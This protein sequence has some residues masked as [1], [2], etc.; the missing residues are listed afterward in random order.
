M[1]DEELFDIYDEELRHLGTATRA[2][3]HAKGYWHRSFHCWLAHRDGDRQLVRFQLRQLV[4]DTNPGCFDITV[5]GHLTA[6]ETLRDAI[7]ELEEE[8]GVT[9]DFDELLPLGQIREEDEGTVNG[10][11]FIDREVSD[12]FALVRDVPLTALRLQPEEVA[13]VY[14]A[15]IAELLALFDGKQEELLAHGI[16]LTDEPMETGAPDSSGAIGLRPSTRVVRASLFVPRDNR[17]YI[18]VMKKLLQLV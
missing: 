2:E 10:K 8:I 7:R 17:Y 6:G 4:K 18:D 12:V 14:E 15:E 11:L 3:T 9:A 1:S 5:A 16:E 13:G